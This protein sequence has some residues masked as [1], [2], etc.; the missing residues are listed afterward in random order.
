MCKMVKN[1]FIEVTVSK[2]N[3][4]LKKSQLVVIEMILKKRLIALDVATMSSAYKK[5]T[6]LLGGRHLSR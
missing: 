3:I 2:K 5:H 6:A 1:L 4:E